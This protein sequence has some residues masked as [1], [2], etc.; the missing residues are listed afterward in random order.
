MLTPLVIV[1]RYCLLSLIVTLFAAKP[2]FVRTSVGLSVLRFRLSHIHYILHNFSLAISL[3]VLVD[4]STH[5]YF[6][7][8]CSFSLCI[9]PGEGP[10]LRVLWLQSTT[11]WQNYQTK[12]HTTFIFILFGKIIFLCSNRL[13]HFI[14]NRR[15]LDL[16]RRNNHCTCN[17]NKI[18]KVWQHP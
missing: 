13:G 7:I 4:Q 17:K 10:N 8:S 1:L 9:T 14:G 12:D 11:T 15:V 5:P 3:K 6:E 2:F 18:K 16:K